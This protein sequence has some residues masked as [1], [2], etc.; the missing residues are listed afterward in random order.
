MTN[1]TYSFRSN[2][3]VIGRMKMTFGSGMTLWQMK[4][5]FKDSKW[6]PCRMNISKV[7]DKAWVVAKRYYCRYVFIPKMIREWDMQTKVTLWT[8][9]KSLRK[10]KDLVKCSN[11]FQL[12]IWRSILINSAYSTLQKTYLSWAGLALAKLQ[13]QYCDSSAKKPH[14]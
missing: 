13:Q 14:I 7:L 4:K 11:C 12:L 10:D 3:N 5:A 1:I 9:C 8:P 2:S 6:V